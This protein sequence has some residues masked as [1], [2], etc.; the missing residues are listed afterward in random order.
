MKVIKFN[1]KTMSVAEWAKET[2]LI[3]QTIR[4]RLSLGWSIA[5]TL[6]K[7]LNVRGRKR[8]VHSSV[9]ITALD[10]LVQMVEA[11]NLDMHLALYRLIEAHMASGK[12]AK[13]AGKKALAQL[14]ARTRLPPGVVA[15]LT[16]NAKHRSF[17]VAQETT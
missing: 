1:G 12:V 13:D 9:K 7:P 8:I 4:A 5:D 16:K 2:G 3:P 15:D 10:D 14:E 6:T 17:P 11:I